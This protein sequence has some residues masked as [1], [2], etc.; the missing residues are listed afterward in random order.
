LD[1]KENNMARQ[2]PIDT[3][4]PVKNSTSGGSRVFAK[5]IFDS[6]RDPSR[7]GV[8]SSSDG[9]VRYLLFQAG[10]VVIDLRFEFSPESPRYSLTGQAQNTDASAPQ[11]SEIVVSL[12]SNGEELQRV[13][14]NNFG[15]FSLESEVG[16]NVQI[17]L[18]VVLETDV[19][20]PLE[21]EFW[22]ISAAG[23]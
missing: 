2:K 20:V 8:R 22:R 10:S 21:D 4:A 23:L 17:Q 14:T 16:R 19:F 13:R 7:A 6:F 15:E 1:W 3:E 18:H 5:L 12:R 11:L 9:R